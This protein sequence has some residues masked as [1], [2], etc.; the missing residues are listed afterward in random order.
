VS[1]I[2]DGGPAFPCDRDV[3][4]EECGAHAREITPHS[5]MSLRDYF[6]AHVDDDS[7]VTPDTVAKAAAE[8]GI[9]A[10]D[11]DNHKHF[12]ILVAMA[13]YRYADAMIARRTT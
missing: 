12:P 11:Y 8:L 4:C 1:E 13:R 6:A 2:N 3:N 5:G 10:K 9:D 7:L